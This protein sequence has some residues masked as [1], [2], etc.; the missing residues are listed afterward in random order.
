[1]YLQN[2]EG[3]FVLDPKYSYMLESYE[4]YNDEVKAWVANKKT[5]VP[6]LKKCFTSFTYEFDRKVG[7]MNQYSVVPTGPV[8]LFG[9]ECVFT[10]SPPPSETMVFS[11]TVNK[12]ELVDRSYRSELLAHWVL[13]LEHPTQFNKLLKRDFNV[14][15]VDILTV[16]VTKKVTN[17]VDPA[18]VL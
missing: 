1:V 18:N 5:I 7:A 16:K 11:L 15:E 2:S 9:S 12:I 3:K 4:T 13:G 8:I 10:D 17:V 6:F 14:E